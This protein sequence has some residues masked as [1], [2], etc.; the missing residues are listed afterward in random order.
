MDVAPQTGDIFYSVED[1]NHPSEMWIADADF[2][3]PRQLTH[4]NS[5]IEKA[6]LGTS[7]NIT[8]QTPV[9]KQLR[10][11]LLFPADYV[12]G[13]SYPLITQVYGGSFLSRIAATIS[14]QMGRDIIFCSRSKVTS[15]FFQIPL[16]T[17]THRFRN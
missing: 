11:A 12:E 1:I 7:Q 8:W 13:Q 3:N 17:P 16:W 5:G 2:Q 10:G 14:E 4:L 15:S 6:P 9:G